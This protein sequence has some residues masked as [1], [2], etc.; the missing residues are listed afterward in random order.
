MYQ[1]PLGIIM[2]IVLQSSAAVTVLVA[3]F[4][5]GGVVSFV[6]AS[7]SRRHLGSA[8]LMQ[9]LSLRRWLSPLL[10][11]IAAC[12]SQAAARLRVAVLGIALILI[13]LD[14]LRIRWSQCREQLPARHRVLSERDVS[15]RFLPCRAGLRDALFRRRY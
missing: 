7:G 11:V 14:L 9:V 6:P 3:G 8:L 2:A 4:A 13:S 15:R 10:L 1:A 5:G 12:C